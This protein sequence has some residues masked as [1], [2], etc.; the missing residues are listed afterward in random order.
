[1]VGM[2]ENTTVETDIRASDAER[3][4]TADLIRE[5]AIDGRLTM[6]ELEERLSWTYA[7][8]LRHEL[9]PLVADLPAPPR[10]VPSSPAARR[11]NGRDQVALGLHAVL[12]VALVVAVLTSWVA[13]GVAFFWPVFPIFWALLSLAVHAGLRRFGPRPARWRQSRPVGVEPC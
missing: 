11:L 6:A 1:M 10:P 8:Q 4:Q 13:G 9:P 2:D 7:A 5:A 3:E 12:V